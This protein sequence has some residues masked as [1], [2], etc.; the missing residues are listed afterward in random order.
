MVSL[1]DHCS[2]DKK[3]KKY[4]TQLEQSL[5]QILNIQHQ[6]NKHI[7]PFKCFAR[8]LSTRCFVLKNFLVR[9]AHSIVFW[10][11]QSLE[12]IVRMRLLWSRCFY[13]CYILN[14]ICCEF[15]FCSFGRRRVVIR[16][17]HV[18]TR[19]YFIFSGSVCVTVEDDEHSAFGKPTENAV[20]KRGD[21][22]GVRTNKLTTT[23]TCI[24][25]SRNP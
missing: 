19:F 12:K 23:V 6:W 18:A 17:G 4:C 16:K 11:L 15:L 24:V 20:L 8:L 10:C 2:C 13:L 14:V 7:T 3:D 22:F 9:C 5:V 25:A 1:T 21:Y